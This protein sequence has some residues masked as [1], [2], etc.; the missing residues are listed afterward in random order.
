MVESGISQRLRV[1]SALEVHMRGAWSGWVEIDKT[2]DELVARESVLRILE[3]LEEKKATVPS[4]NPKTTKLSALSFPSD[5]GGWSVFFFFRFFS[6]ELDSRS[7]V[8]DRD[9]PEAH[10]NDVTRAEAIACS[11]MARCELVL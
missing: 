9:S 7:A 2:A 11:A 10:D 4:D 1:L 5:D 8:W 6:G 3:C